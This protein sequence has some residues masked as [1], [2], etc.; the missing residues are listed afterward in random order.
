M[1]DGKPILELVNVTKEYRLPSGPGA[2]QVLKGISLTV[3]EGESIAVTGPSGSGKSTL[4]N[5]MGALDHPTSGEV[6]LGGRNLAGLPDDDLADIRNKEVGFV[7]QLHHLLP[8]CTV[9][10]NVLIP[11]LPHAPRRHNPE[12]VER[13]RM[14]LDRVG[15][16]HRLS[17]RP[18]QLSGGECQRAAVVRALINQPVLVLADEPTGS[19]DHATAE[20]LVQLLEELHIECDTTL[21]M[22][23]HSEELAGRMGRSIPLADGQLER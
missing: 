8:Q 7:F 4:L 10:E 12:A 18:G 15:L 22:V 1:E 19:L 9:L 20:V 6:R 13:A 23:T 21:V 2:L 11:T 3:S 5:L 14:L 16:I 17:H